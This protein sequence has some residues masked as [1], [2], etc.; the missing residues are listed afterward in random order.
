MLRRVNDEQQFLSEDDVHE[1]QRI[2]VLY[3]MVSPDHLAGIFSTT[4][5][6]DIISLLSLH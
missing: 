4:I 3:K 2:P 6:I 1:V 5:N